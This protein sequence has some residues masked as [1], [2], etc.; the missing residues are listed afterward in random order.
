[1][2]LIFFTIISFSL[3]GCASTHKNAQ[4]FSEANIGVP[5]EEKAVLVLYRKLVPPV[6]FTVKAMVDGDLVAKLPN[7]AFSWV[8]VK[9][10]EHKISFSW[11]GWTLTSGQSE[12]VNV[13]SG[14]FYFVELRGGLGY[15]VGIS[16]VVNDISVGTYAEKFED[17]NSCCKYVPANF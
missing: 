9:P 10:G 8:Y 3:L 17:I 11:P 6:A 2:K 14:R 13:E 12:I 7:K 5:T 16:Y 4:S 1:M 15:S